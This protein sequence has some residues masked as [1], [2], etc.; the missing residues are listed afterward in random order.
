VPPER[1]RRALRGRRWGC[2]GAKV[3]PFD[4]CSARRQRRKLY[5]YLHF[6]KL[7]SL[8]I[9][10]V[11][12]AKTTPPRRLPPE[13]RREQLIGVAMEIAAPEGYEGL[14]L[15]EVA[16]RAGVTRTLVYHYFPRGRRDLFLAAVGR[17]GEELTGGWVTESDI[18]LDRKLAANFARIIDYAAEPTD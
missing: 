15:D 5:S 10:A 14:T 1:A 3:D 18:P 6:V 13:Q 17:A 9:A 16:A 7:Y 4:R 12:T 8:S 11:A 2:S